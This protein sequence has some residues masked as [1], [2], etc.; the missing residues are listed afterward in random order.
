MNCEWEHYGKRCVSEFINESGFC[1]KH[2]GE[3]CGNCGRG[4]VMGCDYTGSF[5]C[6]GPCCEHCDACCKQH[7]AKEPKPRYT[8]DY[9]DGN[10]YDFG[11]YMDVEEICKLL[12]GD[13]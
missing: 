4:A 7:G 9:D 1:S 3:K 2:A 6:G 12:N 13:K 5:V 11:K 10:V 8:F